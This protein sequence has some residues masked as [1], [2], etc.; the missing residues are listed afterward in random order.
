MT[1]AVLLFLWIGDLT[2]VG[3]LIDGISLMPGRIRWSRIGGRARSQRVLAIRRGD[4][5]NGVDIL[6]GC[7]RELRSGALR[8]D[9][10]AFHLSLAEGLAATGRF[11]ES[12][13]LIDD[14]IRLVETN[15]DIINMPELLRVKGTFL[16]SMPQPRVDEAEATLIRSLELS[17]RQGARAGELRTAI[18]LARLMTTQGRREA[19]R[20]LLQLVHSQFDE[21]FDTADLK[22]AATL[23]A[24]LR[25]GNDLM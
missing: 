17:R 7:L 24:T 18:D 2:Y 21:G 15:G 22:S 6:Q 8:V 12:I 20:A 9:G 19:A 10:C 11:A 5:Q 1:H 14:G 4:A 3:M 13:R 16:S 23:L 25:Q